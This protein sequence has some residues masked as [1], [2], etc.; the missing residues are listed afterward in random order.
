MLLQLAGSPGQSCGLGATTDF[1]NWLELGPV[2]A[3]TNGLFQFTD[4]NA[5]LYPS[6]FYRWHSP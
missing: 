6:R 3:G 5:P 2:V 4:T 1:L